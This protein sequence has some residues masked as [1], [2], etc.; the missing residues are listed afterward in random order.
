MIKIDTNR[1]SEINYS[2]EIKKM[3]ENLINNMQRTQN[4]RKTSKKNPS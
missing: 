2:N 4:M 3:S 1:N